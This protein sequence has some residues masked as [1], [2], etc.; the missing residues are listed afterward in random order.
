MFKY[1]A[2]IIKQFTPQQRILALLMLLLTIIII[3]VT[4]N[5]TGAIA[6]DPIEYKKQ[7]KEREERI[8][9]LEL[10]IDTLD[11]EIRTNQRK[12]TNE[13]AD[14]ELEFNKM[15]DDVLSDIRKGKK[16]VYN[17]SNLKFIEHS[18]AQSDTSEVSAMMMQKPITIIKDDPVLNQIEGK[19]KAMRNKNKKTDN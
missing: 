16:V 12:C 7:I 14:R 13:I 19:L 6:K 8:D 17:Q 2:D 5:I 3:S 9:D 4:P 15:L 10:T 18:A 11:L 1:I